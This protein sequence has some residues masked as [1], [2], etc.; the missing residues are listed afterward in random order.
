MRHIPRSG[1]NQQQSRRLGDGGTRTGT[2]AAAGV[3]AEVVRQTVVV[4]LRINTA[5]SFAPDDVV[6]GVDDAVPVV[7]A[8]EARRTTLSTPVV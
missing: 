6:G 1:E 4:G 5:K 2:A 8:R 3:L 7:V